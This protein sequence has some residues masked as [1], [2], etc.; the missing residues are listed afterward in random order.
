MLCHPISHHSYIQL[1]CK[2][3]TSSAPQ[4]N[5]PCCLCSPA[6]CSSQPTLHAGQT[7]HIAVAHPP[8]VAWWNATNTGHLHGPGCMQSPTMALEHIDCNPKA[9]PHKMVCSPRAEIC[10][11]SLWIC[12]LLTLSP[13]TWQCHPLNARAHPPASL[14]AS[15]SPMPTLAASTQPQSLQSLS[16]SSVVSRRECPFV[17]PS[18]LEPSPLALGD[19]CGAT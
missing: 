7:L 6:P 8:C 4:A 1:D 9:K 14:M 16:T 19:S 15:C 3:P 2:F 13:N 5:A 11:L 18:T 12:S 10:C 17:L